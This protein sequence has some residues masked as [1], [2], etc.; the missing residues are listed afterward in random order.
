[1]VQGSVLP[2]GSDR[3]SD[4]DAGGQCVYSRPPE[5]AWWS[6]FYQGQAVA[7]AP[8]ETVCS[9]LRSQGRNHLQVEGQG[10]AVALLPVSLSLELVP[11][12]TSPPSLFWSSLLVSIHFLQEAFPVLLSGGLRSCAW[13]TFCALSQS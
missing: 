3:C 9:K 11:H 2:Q 13:P 4:M 12:L 8:A 6:E 10:K 1:M 7:Q 5:N